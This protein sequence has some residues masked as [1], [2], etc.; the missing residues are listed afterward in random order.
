MIEMEALRQN[1]I[2]FAVVREDPMIELELFEKFNIQ[3]PVL[4]ASGGCT[5][6]CISSV[7]KSMELTLIEPNLHQIDLI[8]KK[9]RVL[10]SQNKT[11]IFEHFGRIDPKKNKLSFNESGNFE[12]LFRQFRDFIFEFVIDERSFRQLLV[13][14][15]NSQW[16]ELF[17]HPYW[18]VA[19]DLFFSDALL[20]TMFGSLA[21]QHGPK[22]SYPKYF[23]GVLEAGLLRK[24]RNTN[25]FL[26]HI[27]LGGYINNGKSLPLYLVHPPMHLNYR[28]LN[29]LAGNVE[30]YAEYDFVGLSNIFDWSE[31]QQIAKLA[32][33]LS[34]E[35]SSGSI[36]LFRQLNSHKNFRKYF[37]AKIVWEDSLI[38]RLHKEDRSLFYQSLHLGIKK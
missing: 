17:Q 9:I 10:R 11:K 37:S 2:Q 18:P 20:R 32:R 5:A 19:F 33:K 35:L 24:D 23:R 1:G 26:H 14:G 29:L 7:F 27:F 25:Y 36:I 12:S 22:G 21:I 15:K 3:K 13:R 4:I 16:T 30:S 6:F 31:D 38:N 8:K 28:F 34:N